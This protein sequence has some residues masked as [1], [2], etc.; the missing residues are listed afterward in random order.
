MVCGH[1]VILWLGKFVK[2]NSGC[3]TYFIL[4][5][6][7]LSLGRVLREFVFILE[8]VFIFW[9]TSC[10]HVTYRLAGIPLVRFW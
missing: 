5:I 3:A 8:F 2:L 1:D 10:A 7:L 9:L 6:G 4:V